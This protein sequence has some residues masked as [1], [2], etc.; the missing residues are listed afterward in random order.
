MICFETNCWYPCSRI[1]ITEANN[2]ISSNYNTSTS[3]RRI[4]S[5]PELRP[6]LKS[7][8]LTEQWKKIANAHGHTASCKEIG[9]NSKVRNS[10]SGKMLRQPWG[11]HFFSSALAPG[12]TALAKSTMLWKSDMKPL[13]TS[14]VWQRRMAWQTN[15]GTPS[16]A[17]W[18]E[19]VDRLTPVDL[20]AWPFRQQL[21][22]KGIVGIV[23][24]WLRTEHHFSTSWLLSRGTKK[25]RKTSWRL[26]VL[27]CLNMSYLSVF[28]PCSA[29]S[30]P[31]MKAEL[32]PAKNMLVRQTGQCST[33]KL[34]N[35]QTWDYSCQFN[36]FHCKNWSIIRVNKM[37]NLSSTIR[38]SIDTCLAPP[39]LLGDGIL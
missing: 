19:W 13:Q 35:L 32:R 22:Y 14:V 26:W 23:F 10:K 9:E 30:T 31:E 28:S 11:H 21:S 20:C 1:S 8:C 34:W 7:M 5:L 24:L 17:L 38:T 15:C 3:T 16:L 4:E 6:L 2:N 39:H 29:S 12:R 36:P 33:V 37:N 18:R 25:E 27:A